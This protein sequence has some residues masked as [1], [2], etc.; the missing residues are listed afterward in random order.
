MGSRRNADA[1]RHKILDPK[2]DKT[3]GFEAVA[4]IMPTNFGQ[5]FNATQLEALVQ[6]LASRK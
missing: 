2:S 5:Q 4:G 6:F 1:I 3:K